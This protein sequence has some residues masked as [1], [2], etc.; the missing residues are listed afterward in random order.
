MNQNIW[1]II[2]RRRIQR[3][4]AHVSEETH[5]CGYTNAPWCTF[6]GQCSV[7]TWYYVI[8]IYICV[9][10]HV[11]LYMYV[12]LCM[13]DSHIWY[14]YIYYTTSIYIYM[15]V[16]VIVCIKDCIIYLPLEREDSLHRNIPKRFTLG[17]KVWCSVPVLSAH[18]WQFYKPWCAM[19]ILKLNSEH[20]VCPEVGMPLSRAVLAEP[21][22]L[23]TWST[24][25]MEWFPY[26]VMWRGCINQQ[27]GWEMGWNGWML[28]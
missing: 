25:T 20:W 24:G 8:Y 3:S 14:I 6:V 27:G 1:Y 23:G 21:L 12:Y 11:K 28:E 18:L 10:V 19:S 13:H 2:M 26:K 7:M 17:S 9:C 5:G 4:A 15:Y 16:C 22:P